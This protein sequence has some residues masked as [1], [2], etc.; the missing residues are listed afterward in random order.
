MTRWLPALRMARR[1]LWSHKGRSL[2][3]AFLVALPVLVAVTVAQF[4][5]N[6]RWTGEQAARAAMGGADL[7]VEVSPWDRVEVTYWSGDM[8]YTAVK[9]NGEPARADR[10]P[11]PQRDASS[12]D[13]AA[14]MPEGSRV[15]D[16][17]SYGWVVLAS[18]GQ[19]SVEVID[20]SDPMAEGLGWVSRG[21]APIAPDEVALD[22]GSARALELLD[23]D[24][25]PLPDASLQLLDGTTVRVVGV[26]DPREREVFAEGVEMIAPPGGVVATEALAA[27]QQDEAASYR[28]L[29]DLPGTSGADL[30]ELVD[31]LAA[32][33]V[34]AMPRQAMFDPQEWDVQYADDGPVDAAALAV[35]ALVV[36]FGLIE[37]VLLVGSAFAVGARRQVRDLGLVAANGGAAGDVR[38]VLLA[39][40]LVLGV[41]AS[42]LGAVAGVVVF[43]LG[44]PV[45]EVVA[46]T[47]VW[48]QDVDWFLVSVLT[49]LGAVTG[50]AA[51]LAPAWSIG[52]MSPVDALSGRFSVGGSGD[53]RT[54]RPATGLAILGLV[55]LVASGWWIS[56]EFAA[57]GT[58]VP[59]EPYRSQ[60]SGVPVVI[61]AVGLVLLIGGLTW[62]SP[63]VVR[64]IA[65]ASR[66][67]SVSGR[68]ALREASRHRFRTAASAVSLMIT[69]A[70]MVF[71][72]F[73][74]QAASAEL[75]SQAGDAGR[76]W[77]SITVATDELPE[78][79]GPAAG[80]QRVAGVIAAVEDQVGTSTTYV[81]S[82]AT[83][84]G[85]PYVEPFLGSRSMP[86]DGVRV[87][88]E[89]SLR[90]LVD[91]DDDV[92]AAFADGVVVTTS[93][94]SV[95]DG[96]VRV[97]FDPG[98][99]TQRDS[100][101]LPAIAARAT[102]ADRGYDGG[103]AWMSPDTAEGLGFVVSPQTVTVLTPRDITGADLDA[104]AV[105]GI[106]PS[107][108]VR[109]LDTASL[110]RF[111]AL[112]AAALLTLVV[113]GIAV[114]LS[115]AEGRAD[116]ATMAAVGAG[117]WRR[118]LVGAMHGLF[119]GVVGALLGAAIGL[120]AGAALM[121]VDG[122]P[123]TGIP[124]LVLLGL[125]LVPLL[126][127]VA[128][129]LATSTRLTMVRRTG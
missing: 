68:F 112:G 119:I 2:L 124:W 97:S 102:G 85:V 33:G 108:V 13:V 128:G 58:S 126:A 17:R 116:Q 84:P 83:M 72:G 125:P 48:T 122:M 62:L 9:P 71:A 31:T 35:G 23:D 113:V 60:P 94:G 81:T 98:D 19:A 69:V 36:L 88:D 52:R 109:D 99:R 114:S 49:L 32:Q 46:H 63:H 41:G 103:S 38:R 127:W 30:H 21:A 51:A 115:A 87:V 90:Q 101:E 74:V 70:G 37:V 104:L 96:Q 106:T 5:T 95:V 93:T 1:D 123:G 67:L 45:Y 24:G 78:E 16:H 120:P 73:A 82:R 80:A 26:V 43:R 79:V 18:G 54:H 89:E 40:G 4:H 105:E 39:Q 12:V 64:R 34:A 66:W 11:K 121:Q 76:R 27:Q 77:M 3:M 8:G 44:V 14:L 20:A 47:R 25:D 42:A 7:M 53:L 111:A 29:V 86:G 56:A 61:G 22:A 65:G 15:I 50:L 118:R 110:L 57:V 28:F 59:T 55:V 92:L 75:A 100:W 129:W 6:L 10:S 117:P 91:V 107:T